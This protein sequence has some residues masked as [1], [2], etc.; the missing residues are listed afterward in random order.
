MNLTKAEIM[1]LIESV[2]AVGWN[3]SFI[4]GS[5]T[6]LGLRAQKLRAKL[7]AEYRLR[8]DDDVKDLIERVKAEDVKAH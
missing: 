4:P 1:M 5:T 8:D 6:T 7:V 2:D 3:A